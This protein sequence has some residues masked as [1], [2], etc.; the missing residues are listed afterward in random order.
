MKFEGMYYKYILEI[1]Y[2]VIKLNQI[3]DFR[4]GKI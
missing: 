4:T 3:K 1:T 2:L